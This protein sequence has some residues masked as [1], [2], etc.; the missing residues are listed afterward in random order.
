MKKLLILP[1]LALLF[2]GCATLTV[3]KMVAS[4]RENLARLSPGMNKAK[5]LAIMGTR[6]GV[7]NC[8]ATGAKPYSGTIL[9]NPYRTEMV[10]VAGRMLE[11]IYYMTDSKKENCAV[12]DDELTPLVF[13]N[14]KLI[15][16]G[17]IFM[18]DVI[19]Q[20]EQKQQPSQ[21]QVAVESTPAVE[22]K[23][24]EVKAVTPAGT[25]ADATPAVEAKTQESKA[26]TLAEIDKENSPAQ[27]QE[28][29]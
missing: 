14:G 2:S 24:Q 25:E 9:S 29:K 16:W 17:K 7:Y 3:S 4:N 22:A 28:A 8:D 1:V 15:G 5:T 19:P 10:Q 26:V 13:E 18:S 20:A 12:V 6:S 21:G 23:T 27:A 11:V